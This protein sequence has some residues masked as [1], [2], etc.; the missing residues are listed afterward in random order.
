MSSFC[1]RRIRFLLHSALD[2][3]LCLRAGRGSGFKD[4][5]WMRLV[6][7]DYE[8]TQQHV[9]IGPSGTSLHVANNFDLCMEH[10][11]INPNVGKDIIIMKSCHVSNPAK[12][13]HLDY[14][15][16]HRQCVPPDAPHFVIDDNVNIGDTLLHPGPGFAR[17]CGIGLL[18]SQG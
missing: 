17:S 2:D 10:A 3:S 9:V 1:K 13:W 6:K 14:S 8:D 4:G 12:P 15:V 7:C 11:G 5:T 16:G 18:P